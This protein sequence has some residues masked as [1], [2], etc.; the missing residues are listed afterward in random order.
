MFVVGGGG[1]ISD[2]RFA[3]FVVTACCFIW[4]PTSVNVRAI[5][6]ENDLLHLKLFLIVGVKLSVMLDQIS[7]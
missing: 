5:R 7:S 4:E 3:L 1:N 6:F 2:F